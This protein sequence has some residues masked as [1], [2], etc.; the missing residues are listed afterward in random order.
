MLYSASV[1]LPASPIVSVFVS[2]Y[3]Q[4][5]VQYSTVYWANGLNALK[6][7]PIVSTAAMGART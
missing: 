7:A 5:Y 6:M 2:A 1:C 3:V 4:L